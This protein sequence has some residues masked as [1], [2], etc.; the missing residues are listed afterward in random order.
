MGGDGIYRK[1]EKGRSEIATRANKLGLRERTMLIIV[2]D[3]T[4]RSAL[5]SRSAHPSTG[6][7]LDSLLAQGFIEVTPPA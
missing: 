5:I 6:D 4:P 2:D 7:I 3:K 1:T